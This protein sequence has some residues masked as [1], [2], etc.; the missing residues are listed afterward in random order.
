MRP[1]M[2]NL[3]VSINQKGFNLVA[4][5]RLSVGLSQPNLLFSR[6]RRVPES[7]CGGKSTANYEDLPWTLRNKPLT[8]LRQDKHLGILLRAV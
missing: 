4:K 1:Q 2:A 7:P 6:I 8:S 5:I 3:D